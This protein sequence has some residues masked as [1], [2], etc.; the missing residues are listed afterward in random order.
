M[1]ADGRDVTN[2]T[3]SRKASV[4]SFFWQTQDRI[5]LLEYLAG[6]SAISELN[7]TDNSTRTIWKG[8]EGIHDVSIA[9][10]FP[11]RLDGERRVPAVSIL[12]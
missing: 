5:L 3:S 12:D 10:S 2:R 11:R 1:S 8:P 6:G 4:N 7:P 9:N